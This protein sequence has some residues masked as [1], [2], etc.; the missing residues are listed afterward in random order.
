[1]RWT[2][3]P[4]CPR[5]PGAR[6]ELVGEPVRVLGTTVDVTV[7]TS[8]TPGARTGGCFRGIPFDPDSLVISG[9]GQ[10]VAFTS[11]FDNL[12]VGD[13]NLAFDVLVRDFTTNTTILIII[14][15]SPP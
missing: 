8:G 13:G 12:V 14:N 4:H 5:L 3:L 6:V 15:T 9:D 7:S 10:H 2:G 1:M 11:D